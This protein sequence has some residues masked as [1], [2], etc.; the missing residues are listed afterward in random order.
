MRPRDILVLDQ[1][2]EKFGQAL[3]ADV[4]NR[5]H[6][7]LWAPLAMRGIITPLFYMKDADPAHEA[8]LSEDQIRQRRQ[9]MFLSCRPRPGERAAGG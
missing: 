1:M 7:A 8:Q 2:V 3:P 4:L 5:I 6:V 9:A